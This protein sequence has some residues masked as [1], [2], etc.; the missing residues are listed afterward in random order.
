MARMNL[1]KR[2]TPAIARNASLRRIEA[3]SAKVA[4]VAALWG[5]VDNGMVDEAGQL[6]DALDELKGRVKEAEEYARERGL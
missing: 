5:D 2:W 1:P 4:E 3:A 6:I